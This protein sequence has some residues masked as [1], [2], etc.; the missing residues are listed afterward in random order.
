MRQSCNHKQEPPPLVSGIRQHDVD[1]RSRL[2]LG[3]V[4]LDICGHANHRQSENCHPSA[5]SPRAI[6]P[7]RRTHVEDTLAA[8]K[9][10]TI[11]TTSQ[12]WTARLHPR[13]SHRGAH[14]W[15]RTAVVD[16]NRSCLQPVSYSS[17]AAWPEKQRRLLPSHHTMHC[18]T[19][20]Y[21][22]CQGEQA[23][24]SRAQWQFSTSL[25]QCTTETTMDH[26]QLLPRTLETRHESNAAHV[27]AEARAQPI[28]SDKPPR[29]LHG[30]LPLAN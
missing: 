17:S 21:A 10:I 15:A 8:T 7:S 25:Q 2:G 24:G 20:T 3:M 13:A 18:P 11:K 5:A 9:L 16:N 1:G 6:G 30:P 12:E 28:T 27:A 4:H 22:S 14:R 23:T 19:C 26:P 29:P